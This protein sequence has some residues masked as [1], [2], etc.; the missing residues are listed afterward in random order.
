M[1]TLLFPVAG[2][3]SL[4]E[5]R[6]ALLIGN[7]GYPE[8][9]LNNPR[10]DIQEMSKVLE[11]FDFKVTTFEDVDM[12]RM[13]RAVGEFSSKLGKGTTGFFYYAGYGMQVSG[14]NYLMPIDA[15]IESQEDVQW[16]AMPLGNVLD[17]IQRAGEGFN[18]IMLDACRDN[19][20]LDSSRS[21]TCGFAKASPTS[22]GTMIM[23]AT[24]PGKI[25]DDSNG[26]NG[27]FTGEFIRTLMEAP[28]LKISELFNRISKNVQISTDGRQTPWS[29]GNILESF[30]FAV[31]PA[32]ALAP[33]SQEPQNSADSLELSIWEEAVRGNTVAYY[34]AYLNQYPEGNASGIARIRIAEL[35]KALQPVEAEQGEATNSEKLALESANS[36]AEQ[37]PKESAQNNL[38]PAD[39]LVKLI[40]QDIQ[41]LKLTSPKDSNANDKLNE[42]E[43]IDATHPFLISGRQKIRSL[44]IAWIEKQVAGGN[45]SKSREYLKS[46]SLVKNSEA[47]VGKYE[48]IIDNAEK[49]AER[50]DTPVKQDVLRSAGS[51]EITFGDECKKPGFFKRISATGSVTQRTRRN[52]RDK[53]VPYGNSKRINLND[54]NFFAYMSL[55]RLAIREYDFLTLIYDANGKRLVRDTHSIDNPEVIN[56]TWTVWYE[57]Q[58]KASDAIGTWTYVVCEGGYRQVVK[59]FTTYRG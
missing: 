29:E 31:K 27:V 48:S 1:L 40:E 19:A 13:Q 23:Y 8:V 22:E 11:S 51:A 53:D 26:E 20:Y 12:K 5:E 55:P 41:S 46:M 58:P 49:T 32:L 54:G 3:Q 42:L 45:F 39:Q 9:P 4:A 24:E 33:E 44:Y 36:L 15:R 50:D 37:K 10:N 43:V 25:A 7:S 18:M 57:Y 35:Q 16:E 56:Y 21:L 52:S 47:D 17:G 28:E 59:T 14:K 30:S 2:Q 38:V 6:I 34:E